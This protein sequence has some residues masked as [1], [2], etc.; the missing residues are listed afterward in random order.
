MAISNPTDVSSAANATPDRSGVTVTSAT[1]TS[2]QLYLFCYELDLAAQPNL[3][4]GYSFFHGAGTD[5]TASW[6]VITQ[7]KFGTPR[8]MCNYWYLAG[9]TETV[10]LN[11]KHAGAT[12]NSNF[13]SLAEIASGFNSSNPISQSLTTAGTSVSAI[14]G[15]YSST[16]AADSL[17]M[18]WVGSRAAS[19]AITQRTGWTEL[20]EDLG[21]G[22]TADSGGIE[23]Q[24][25]AGSDKTAGATAAGNRTWGMIAAEIAI[26]AA[27]GAVIS[28]YYANYYYP[29]VVGR[30]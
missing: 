27:A 25:L 13:Y 22:T 14:T 20:S 12:P 15:E 11:F 9:T 26:A 3:D 17:C 8:V 1:F 5:R 4:S 16:P 23:V 21:T 10:D 6:S 28:P 30:C 24:Y 18:A 29:Q 19:G 2:G 7:V